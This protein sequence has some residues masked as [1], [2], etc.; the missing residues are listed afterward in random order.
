MTRRAPHV[1][2]CTMLLTAADLSLKMLGLR[3]SARLARRL[4]Q[5]AP[6]RAGAGRAEVMEIARRVATAAAFYPGRA[7]CLEQSLALYVLLRRRG[8]G[9]DLRIGVQPFP[10]TAHAWVE[11]EGRPVNER[12]DF[13][14]RLAAFPS[15]G[16]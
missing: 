8:I 16:G 3:R 6:N 9:A 5:R 4:A 13:V 1:L 11:Y 10:F 15:L 2:T 14:T 12:E 7:Q